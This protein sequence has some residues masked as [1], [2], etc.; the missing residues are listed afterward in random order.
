M[1]FYLSQRTGSSVPF[2]LSMYSM[3][4]SWQLSQSPKKQTLKTTNYTKNV[5]S[6][7]PDAI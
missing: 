5:V 7:H 3:H 4:A 2:N 6:R 1:K